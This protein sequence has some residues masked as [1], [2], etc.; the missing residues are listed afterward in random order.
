MLDQYGRVDALVNNAATTTWDQSKPRQCSRSTTSSKPTCS[1]SFALTKSFLPIFRA[2]RSGVIVNISSISADQGYPYT[3]AYAASKA[4]VA[5]FTEGLNLEM[6]RFG[7]SAKA[8]VPGPRTRSTPPP[9]SRSTALVRL[10]AKR[11]TRV[12]VP[13]RGRGSDAIF[14]LQSH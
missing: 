2:Q 14:Q 4:A 8:V 11:L 13:N 9:V 5:A 10:A 12:R 7:V 6:S 1:A 3:A